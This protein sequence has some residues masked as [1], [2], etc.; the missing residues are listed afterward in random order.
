MAHCAS[1]SSLLASYGIP[2]GPGR[3]RQSL[4]TS[5]SQDTSTTASIQQG[6][7]MRPSPS[8][9]PEEPASLQ[10]LEGNPLCEALGSPHLP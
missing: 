4:G 9:P 3:Q 10:D 1:S 5:K 6:L 2:L 7:G 8:V